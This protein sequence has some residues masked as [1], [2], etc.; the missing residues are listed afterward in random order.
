ML[1]QGILVCE[2]TYGLFPC[3]EAK[4]R[5][6]ILRIRELETVFPPIERGVLYRGKSTC[7]ENS[8]DITR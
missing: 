8:L 4:V 7:R 3:N 5:I 6:W 2:N 1:I